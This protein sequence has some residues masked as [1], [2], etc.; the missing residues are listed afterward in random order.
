MKRR[1]AIPLEN[2][3]L[4]SHFGHSRLFAIVETDGNEI[5]GRDSWSH[6]RMNMGRYLNGWLNWR[7]LM[8]LQGALGSMQSA[9]WSGRIYISTKV[10]GPRGP[11][12]LLNSSLE[13][14]EAKMPSLT[15]RIDQ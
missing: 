6:H 7:L 12:D 11:I 5:T 10:P 8:L 13:T 4:H 1:I 2:G 15:S 14:G 9:T 3:I